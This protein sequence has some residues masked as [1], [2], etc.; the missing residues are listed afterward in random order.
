[1]LV[2]EPVVIKAIVEERL[3]VADALAGGMLRIYPPH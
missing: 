1:M 2:T 3:P